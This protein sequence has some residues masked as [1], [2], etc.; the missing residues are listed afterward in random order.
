M[1]KSLI[2]SFNPDYM[3]GSINLKQ[4]NLRSMVGKLNTMIV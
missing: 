3:F 2:F 1:G 4:E